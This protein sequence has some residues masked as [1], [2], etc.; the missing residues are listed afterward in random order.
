MEKVDLK[1]AMK[2][3]YEP[4]KKEVVEVEV[5]E[6]SFLMVDG[7]GDPNTSKAY[8]DAAKALFALSYALKF[9]IKKGEWTTVLCPSK[10]S[11][12]STEKRNLTRISRVTGR[13]G[14]GPR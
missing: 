14:G 8:R 6:M 9:A 12:G 1:K 4:S 7:Q 10:G 2:H 11:G 3:L 13:R 5:P